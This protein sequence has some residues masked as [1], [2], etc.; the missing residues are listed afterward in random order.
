M[1]SVY[2]E[3]KDYIP[4]QN[5]LKFR[6]DGDFVIVCSMQNKLHYL[7][8]TAG[9]IFKSCNK[10]NSIEMIFWGLKN[11]YDAPDE[12]LKKD[13]IDTIRYFQWN[14]IIGLKEPENQME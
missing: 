4:F 1:F 13:L 7:N 10:T 8:D 9:F 11:E 3:M 5:C 6:D 12:V 14:D 2:D